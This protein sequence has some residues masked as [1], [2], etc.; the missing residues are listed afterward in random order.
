MTDYA[1]PDD[2]PD[3]FGDPDD[4]PEP[5]PDIEVAGPNQRLMPWLELRHLLGRTR[6]RRRWLQFVTAVTDYHP[7]PKQ[8]RAHLANSGDEPNVRTNKLVTSGIRFGKTKWMVHE[9]LGLQVFNP[10][11]D[12]VMVAP[13]YDQCR[14]VLIKE[15]DAAVTEMARRGYPLLRRWNWSL[16]RADLHCGARVFFRS[17]QKMDN[18][19][20]FEFA[21]AGIDESDYTPEPVRTMH[22]VAGRLSASRAYLRQL[23][24]TTTP[25]AYPGS[26]IE[27]FAQQRLAAAELPP[28]ER[29]TALR[30]WWFMRGRTLDNTTLPPDFIRGLYTLSKNEWLK[31]VEGFP[32][33]H[34]QA[35]VLACLDAT[36]HVQRE[37]YKAGGLTIP[38]GYDPTLPYHLGC[39]WG[40]HRPSYFWIQ[41]RRDG[42]ALIFHEWH[43]DDASIEQQFVYLKRTAEVLGKAPEAAATDRDPDMIELLRKIFPHCRMESAETKAEQARSWSVTAL[44]RLLE[45]REGPPLLYVSSELAKPDASKRGFMAMAENLTFEWDANRQCYK[46]VA[47]KDG[48]YDH[49]FDAIAYWAKLIGV[50]QRQSFQLRQ[51]TSGR[52]LDPSRRLEDLRRQLGMPG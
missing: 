4:R 45:P 17:A 22:T 41:T 13:T 23:T 15:W 20:G 40:L 6:D 24:A 14:E 30:A 26:I 34:Q 16:L 29:A 25:Y 3:D 49:A 28:A 42:T 11:C 7:F 21:S 38:A 39:D 32:I 27:F 36:K 37:P 9:H 12:H 52:T 35:L 33:I 10:G 43:P 48:T 8:I 31:E 2:E 5:S 51:A 44:L 18:S 47:N 50:V 1:P 19:R 46:D